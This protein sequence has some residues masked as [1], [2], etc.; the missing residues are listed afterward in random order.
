MKLLHPLL[1]AYRNARALR[2]IFAGLYYIAN[3]DK[4]PRYKTNQ[5]LRGQMPP[6][7]SRFMT[8]GEKAKALIEEWEGK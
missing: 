3:T 8:P 2:S 4:T 5:A 7:G 1:H 6:L